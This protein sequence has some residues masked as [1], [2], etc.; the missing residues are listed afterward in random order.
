MY[1]L[2][3]FVYR[4]YAKGEYQVSYDGKLHKGNGLLYERKQK[5]ESSP[6]NV[7]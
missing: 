1:A 5:Q 4:E 7:I 2:S 3:V 6:S